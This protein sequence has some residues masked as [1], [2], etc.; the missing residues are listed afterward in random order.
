M[1]GEGW[2][3][4]ETGVFERNVR[5][6]CAL[7]PRVDLAPFAARIATIRDDIQRHE[8][9][10]DTDRL[11]F[12]DL[13]TTGLSGG[14]GTVAFLACIG[15]LERGEF[16]LTQ[17]FLDDY[18]YEVAYLRRL[19]EK[20]GRDSVCV[21]YNGAS[22][23]MPL[24]AT[25][26]SMN[27]LPP[28]IGKHIDALKTVRRLWKRVIGSVS[29]EH[30]ELELFR[31]PREDDIP[32]AMIPAIWFSHVRN[33][34]DPRLEIVFEHNAKDVRSLERVVAEAAS[35]FQSPDRPRVDFERVGR[36][37]CAVGRSVEGIALL[38]K[39]AL[40]QGDPRAAV[41]AA[42]HAVRRG[43]FERALA[44]LEGAD[45]DEPRWRADVSIFAARLRL[46]CFR[47]AEGARTH[48]QA[49]LTAARRLGSPRRIE[50]VERFLE[51]LVGS[52]DG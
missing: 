40:E 37:L 8:E 26:L 19:V 20:L 5:F 13:E 22:F 10:I 12:F 4:V 48:A 42:R 39:A 1:L 45:V 38:E 36:I 30:V 2:A 32:G 28:F 29:L 23:D 18:P 17:I 51:R 7:G 11:R 33:G 50:V 31:E 46:R 9:T 35:V 15:R 44:I 49:A 14:S 27:R 47:D 16:S 25:R 41:A 3:R 43:D 24:L 34:Y 21:T 6:P 52:S